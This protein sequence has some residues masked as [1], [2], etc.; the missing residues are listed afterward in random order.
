MR[1]ETIDPDGNRKEETYMEMNK[2]VRRK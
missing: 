2:P 1:V